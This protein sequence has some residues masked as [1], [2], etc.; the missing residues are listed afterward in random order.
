MTS[1][2]DVIV[3]AGAG[4]RSLVRTADALLRQRGRAASIALVK[5]ER[6][7][8]TAAGGI[9]GSRVCPRLCSRQRLPRAR[10]QC[11]VGAVTAA[12]RRVAAGYTLN[13]LFSNAAKRV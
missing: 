6:E 8:G 5:S 7:S 4:G 3:Q 11:A 2:A 12:I 9:G 13:G 10:P 1:S